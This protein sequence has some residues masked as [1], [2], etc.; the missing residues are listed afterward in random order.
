MQQGCEGHR[1][2]RNAC[3]DCKELFRTTAAM[4]D[5]TG[6]LEKKIEDAEMRN[7]ILAAQKRELAATLAS[8]KEMHYKKSTILPKPYVR[9]NNLVD[10]IQNL[11]LP[12]NLLTIVYDPDLSLAFILQKGLARSSFTCPCGSPCSLKRQDSDF[13]FICPCGQIFHIFR[14]TI[15]EKFEFPPGKLVLSF[16]LWTM[17]L[18]S[19]NIRQ[20]LSIDRDMCSDFCATL[21]KVIAEYYVETLPKFR[22]VVEID[23]SCFKTYSDPKNK[24]LKDRWVFGLYERERKLVYMQVVKKR[25]AKTLIPIIQKR[26]EVGTTIISDQW[27]AYKKLEEFGYPHYTVDHSRFFVNPHSREIHTQ[28][29]E[30]SWC[31]AKYSVKKHRLLIQMQAM[32][33]VFCWMRQ[34]RDTEK[35]TEIAA[36]LNSA[37]EIVRKYQEKV[38]FVS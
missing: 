22:G 13:F 15:F 14:N 32:L 3:A 11:T 5:E 18:T 26:C 19:A 21:R 36:I 31:W 23:E 8:V 28:N 17:N 10:Y 4:A 6:E 7:K 29:I 25:D 30:I 9:D 1:K 34:F 16:F 27:S 33:H 12:M 35:E 24:M 2:G 37:A 38:V 20:I